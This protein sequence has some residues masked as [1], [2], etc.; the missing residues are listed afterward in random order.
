[1]VVYGEGRYACPEHGV[2][3]PGPRAPEALDAGEFEPP[4][5]VCARA[6]EP[7]TVPEDAALDPRNVYAATKVAQEHLCAAYSRETGVPVTAL[8][9]H[10]VYGPRMPRDTPYAGVASIFR[11]SL[12]AGEAPRVYEDGGMRRD[13]VHVRDVARANVLALTARGAGHRRLQ[14]GQRDAA[15]RARHGAGARPRV[16]RRRRAAG[17]RAVARRRRAARVRVGGPRGGAAGLQRARGLRGRDARVR[18]GAAARMTRVAVVGHVE[19]IEFARV[20]RLPAPGEIVH[21]TREL[22]GGGR[23][24]RGRRGPARQARGGADFFTA[25]G[26]DERGA[27]LGRA[28]WRRTACGCTRR[29]APSRSGAASRTSTP[30]AS[31]RS[32]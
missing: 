31:A 28:A 1:M 25:L 32:P 7:R 9:Y 14:R 10:N 23:R 26:D 4:C 16:R 30:T 13:F 19:W 3:R 27:P 2:V 15:H 20:P 21:A 5:P 18:L 6:L 29:R 17:H 24:R 22:G 11:S 8:R 12:A